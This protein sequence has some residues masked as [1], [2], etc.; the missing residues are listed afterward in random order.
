MI[1]TAVLLLLLTSSPLSAQDGEALFK[2]NCTACHK[3]DKKMIGPALQGAKAKWAERTGSDE[4]II[5]WV[6]NS[7]A[8]MKTS[9]DDY[10]ISLFEEY[11]KTLMTP[12]ALTSEEVIAVLDYVDNWVPTGGGPV[13]VTGDG[14]SV[15]STEET[16]D[17]TLWLIVAAIVLFIVFR[18][19]YGVSKNL[20]RLNSQREEVELSEEKGMYSD[21]LGL[22]KRY[23]VVTAILGLLVFGYISILGWDSIGSIGVYQGYQP[24]QPIWFSHKIHAGQNGINCVYCHNSVEKGKAAG[25][26]SVNICMNCHM[27][28]QE[29]KVSGTKEIAKIYDAIGWDPDKNQ[30][31]EGYDQKPIEWV[32]IHNLQDF[33]YFNH[34]QHV[35]VGKQECQ[36]CHG[37]IQEMDEVYQYSELTMGWCINCHR[38]TKVTMKDNGYYEEIHSEL[39]EKYKDEGLESFTVEQIGG[40]EC[41]KC[42][43]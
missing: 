31:I 36:T 12:M 24:T 34:S 22:F 27:G 2:A 39:T 26:P 23:K 16:S 1:F 8:Y 30:Y 3:I 33:V 32:R 29:G 13:V 15:A 40:L 14:V 28:V 37:Q 10:A 18:V 43:Y 20:D 11:N 17:P 42:H 7:T 38:E 4:A 41:V 25:I 21:F 6:K 19:L 5:S 35:V 9:G